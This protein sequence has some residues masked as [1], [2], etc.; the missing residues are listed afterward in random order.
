MI[1]VETGE[2]LSNAQSYVSVEEATVY[3]TAFGNSAW[4]ERADQQEVSL[5][6]ATQAI[7]AVWGMMYGSRKKTRAQALLFPRL[8]FYDNNG[9]Y[10]EAD[11]IPRCLKTAVCEMALQ[12]ITQGTDPLEN[13]VDSGIKRKKQ[14]VGD[15]EE[16]IE[17]DGTAQVKSVKEKNSRVNFLLQPILRQPSFGITL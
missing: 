13:D 17:F 8:G 15:L 4:T 11:E 1:V 9:D 16:E 10:V 6:K 14:K 12:Y 5:V 7:D 2:G 3:H